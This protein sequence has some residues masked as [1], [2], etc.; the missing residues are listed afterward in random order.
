MPRRA[1]RSLIHQ[2]HLEHLETRKLLAAFGTPWPNARDLSI[3]FPADGVSIANY[4]N[5]I[6]EELDTVTSREN[7]QELVLRAYQ[8]WAIHADVNIAL[9]PDHDL[10]FGTPGL[11]NQDPRFGEFRIGAF[12]QTGVLANSLPFQSVAGTWSGDL[13]LNSQET[14]IYH[15]WE[16]NLP[17]DPM[18]DPNGA[19]D[20]FSVLLHE[21]G[22]TLGIADTSIPSAVMF[23]HYAGPKGLLTPEDIGWLQALYG[24]RTDPYEQVDNGQLGLATFI[25][26]PIDF[27][28]A[29]DTLDL[30]GSI[31]NFN[32]ADFY[33]VT[34][35]AGQN[36]VTFRVNAVGVSL[37]VPKIEV[38]D[39]NG[40]LLA[41]QISE[42]V[43]DNN[44]SVTVSGLT[45]AGD[46]NIRV[47]AASDDIYS[48][49]DYRLVVDYRSA[50]IRATDPVAGLY[51]AGIESLGTNFALA[52]DEIGLNDTILTAM[53]LAS[54]DGFET[55]AV[56]EMQ[57]S[58]SSAS[59]VD[60]WKITSP[61]EVD[62]RLVVK[63][64]SVGAISPDLRVHIIDANGQ[65]VGARGRLRSDG[66]WV[67]EVAQPEANTQYLI[68]LSVDPNSAV[69]VGNY[70]ASA[71][72]AT[73]ASQMNQ[74]VAGSISSDIDEI[75]LWTSLK[76]RLYRFDLSTFDGESSEAIRVIIYDA[77]TQDIRLIFASPAGTSRTAFALLPEGDYVIRISGISQS[78]AAVTN[79]SYEL[80]ADGISDDQDD[81]GDGDDSS[82]Y[83]Y[84]YDYGSS[85][86]YGGSNYY[87]YYYYYGSWYDDYEYEYTY[88][89]YAGGGGGT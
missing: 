17:P 72:F 31:L 27:D 79:L 88:D 34:P 26:T 60:V 89:P 76:T 67:L 49:G 65:P 69:G 1:L 38:Y 7:W 56:Y 40:V 5:V 18:I 66:T 47:S 43:F 59:D 2:P 44:V 21:T 3:S 14:F 58:M 13:F 20:L 32:D 73:D 74:F 71:E 35:L 55:N 15:D 53:A 62:G 30:R 61:A 75:F 81:D 10:N 54:S 63:V 16:D 86:Y 83:N 78:G 82:Y 12:P 6:H 80:L 51:N 64:A 36:E 25:P 42:S 46:I 85:Y 57:S 22:N 50:T 70:V 68:R 48:V 37:L 87:D 24:A 11:S 33:R 84:N 19:K 29:I 28:P 4:E 39:Q 77:V 23:G 41:Q 8:T 52:D 45:S 9:T